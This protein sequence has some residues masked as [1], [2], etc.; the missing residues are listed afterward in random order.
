MIGGHFCLMIE[1]YVQPKTQS[2]NYILQAPLENTKIESFLDFDNS[3]IYLLQ[4]LLEVYKSLDIQQP[5]KAWFFK[6]RI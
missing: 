3:S 4:Q 2:I 1:R 5:F 6:E